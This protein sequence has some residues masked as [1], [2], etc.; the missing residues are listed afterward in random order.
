MACSNSCREKPIPDVYSV[1]FEPPG[2]VGT[3]PARDFR[4]SRIP[5]HRG[6]LPDRGSPALLDSSQEFQHA[7]EHQRGCCRVISSPTR[8]HEMMHRSRVDVFF[9]Y[10]PGSANARSKLLV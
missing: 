5:M 1:G 6:R 4:Q 3:R 10:C 9:K 7:F 2:Y 8:V